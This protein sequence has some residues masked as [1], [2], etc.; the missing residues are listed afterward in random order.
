MIKKVLTG[1]LVT[2]VWVAA[3][4]FVQALL[5]P[6]YMD[7]IPEGALIA[8]YYNETTDH[9]VVFIGDCE[10]YENFSPVT[11]YEKYGITSY[12]RGSAQ[13]LIWQSYYMMEET[14]K[15]EKPKAFVFNVLS[16]KYNEPQ[17]EAYNRLNLDGMRLSVQKLKAAKASLTEGEDVITYVLPLLRYHAR[18]DKLKEED[19]K[20]LFKREQKSISGFLMRVDVKPVSE[21]MPLPRPLADYT[22]GENSYKYLDMM[23]ELC[24]KNGVELVLIKAPSLYPEWYEQWD[25]QIVA[26]AEKH[27]LL[28][29]NFLDRLEAAGLDFTTD[30]YDMGLHLNLSGAEKLADYFGSLLTQNIDFPDHSGDAAVTAAW[31]EKC[32]F[33]Y[34]MKADQ[35]RELE[36]YGYLK[37]YGGRAPETGAAVSASDVT[38]TDVTPTDVTPTDVTPTDVPSE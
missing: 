30:T 37:S 1:A 9:D 21:S 25:D 29:I 32:D 11:L 13:Q 23:T 19:V 35:Y 27:D 8:E 2:L 3:F 10:V 24:K 17:S 5:T 15:Y 26:Y 31:K 14:L 6:K 36:E 20:Y 7:E 33:Y 28:Y 12:I 4:L 34:A 16:M 22:F 18:W 38:P